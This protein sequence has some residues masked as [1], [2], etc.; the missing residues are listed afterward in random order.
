M[1][2]RLPG[3]Q[4]FRGSWSMAI[5]HIDALKEVQSTLV[6]RNAVHHTSSTATERTY[7]TSHD[8]SS[9]LN[10]RRCGVLQ[11][12]PDMTSSYQMAVAKGLRLAWNFVEP[13]P[14]SAYTEI[15][16]LERH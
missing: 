6:G 13:V 8:H 1:A 4:A 11:P 3:M 16:D 15:K 7:S 14:Q 5:G 10:R 9:A 2:S 12:Q